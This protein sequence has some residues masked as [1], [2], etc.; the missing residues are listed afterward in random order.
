[1]HPKSE[2][3]HPSLDVAEIRVIAFNSFLEV[4][5]GYCSVRR[6]II[7]TLFFGHLPLRAQEARSTILGRITDQTGSVI[8]GAAVEVANTDTGVRSTARTNANGD[9]LLP[10]LIPG[11]Y[12]LA[13]EAPGF[14]KSVRPQI[15]VQVDQHITIDV[16]LEIGQATESVQVKADL[17]RHVDGDV[18]ID[19]T[20]EIGQATES[21][22]VKAE[23]PLLD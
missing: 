11:R 20:L 9:F 14:K 8:V 3:R 4:V 12:S 10:F 23:T 2:I 5:M 13:A 7:A 22:Q 1:M 15:Q 19:V 21:V 18:L 16:T 6:L 17:E